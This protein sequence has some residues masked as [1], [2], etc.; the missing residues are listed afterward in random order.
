MQLL[1][2]IWN[3]QHWSPAL[4]SSWSIP[5]L[6]GWFSPLSL[7]N[8]L[9]KMLPMFVVTHVVGLGIEF[10][11]LP[12]RPR[13]RRRFSGNGSLDSF[14]HATGFAVVD[15]GHSSC[16]CCGVWQRSLRRYRY[17]YLEHRFIDQGLCVFAYPGEISGD[18]CW[19]SG[20]DS[21]AA[22]STAEYGWWHTGFFNS[23]LEPSDGHS[24]Q[25]PKPW[26]LM[27]LVEQPHWL[28]LIRGAW[29]LFNNIIPWTRFSGEVFRVY[30]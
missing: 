19:V 7:P 20:Y 24:L 9:I 12:K 21:L 25:L 4:C 13:S 29:R 27:A 5:G 22:G 30:W 8:G 23:I 6:P 14:D 2:F 10:L 3:V 1:L 28:L 11:L 15:F 17:E 16:I 26:W 18:S